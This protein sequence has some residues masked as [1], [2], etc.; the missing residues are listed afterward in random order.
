[1]TSGT[2]DRQQRFAQLQELLARR[3]V[4]LDGAMGTMLQGRSAWWR[5]TTVGR[6]SA[7]GRGT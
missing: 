7:T 6:A 2:T 5:P 3:I 4:V 1:M